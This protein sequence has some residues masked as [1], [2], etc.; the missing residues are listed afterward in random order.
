M[1]PI[2]KLVQILA[3]GLKPWRLR[4]L[5]CVG[6]YKVEETKPYHEVCFLS[7]FHKAQFRILLLFNNPLSKGSDPQKIISTLDTNL[8]WLRG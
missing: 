1:M 6:F 2:T 4:A 8:H 3:E 5:D 7:R